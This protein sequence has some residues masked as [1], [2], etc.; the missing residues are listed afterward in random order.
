MVV[1]SFAFSTIKQFSNY[2]EECVKIVGI[3]SGV[4]TALFIINFV[5][6]IHG[7]SLTSWNT[8]GDDDS[9]STKEFKGH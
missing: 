3:V 2:I 1:D 4:H 8:S 9:S 5:A 6:V 7:K